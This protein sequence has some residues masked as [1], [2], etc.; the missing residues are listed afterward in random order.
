MEVLLHKQLFQLGFLFSTV[1]FFV[2]Y[3]IL[4]CIIPWFVCDLILLVAV[5]VLPTLMLLLAGWPALWIWPFLFLPLE[6]SGTASRG[7]R[8]SAQIKKKKK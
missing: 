1:V 4:W 2:Y 6:E 8:T 3:L 7:S 5:Y